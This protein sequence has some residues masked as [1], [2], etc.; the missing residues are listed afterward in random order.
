MR[1]P[2]TLLLLWILFFFLNA[3]AQVSI[4]LENCYT[5]A[6]ENYPMIKQRD[7][8]AKS[9]EYS[10]ENASKGYY[11]QLSFYGQATYQSQVTQIPIKL[12]NINIPTIS[13][14]QYKFYGEIN[15]TIYDGGQIRA[16]KESIKANE[17]IEVQK[18]ET[19]IY[20]LKERINQLYFGIL[21]VNEQLKQVDILKKDMASGIAKINA[22]I[23]NG[24][25]LKSSADALLVEQLKA[26]QKTIELKA[27]RNAYLEMLGLYTNQKLTENSIIEK[28]V[29]PA[30][31]NTIQRPELLLYY[32]QSRLLDVQNKLINVKNRPK[33]G[34]FFQGGFGRPALNMLNN[35][36][37]GYCIGGVRLSWSLNGFY[38]AKNDRVIIGINY[39]LIETQKETFLFN[40]NL[41]LKQQSTEI[42]KN[43]E[44]IRTDESIISLRTKIKIRH[45]HNSKMV[46]LI[47]QIMCAK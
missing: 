13:K 22:A 5:L 12:P 27:S 2:L 30:L 8:I 15:Q 10:I 42:N 32:N 33:V 47:L 16:Q 36:F 7:L 43:E 25:A 11:P 38:T 29:T 34:L 20:K 37:T 44:L 21:L 9:A 18:L 39:N 40:T 28:P 19:E 31:A 4:T 6:R 17:I 24:V 46:P 45:W 41:A 26:D 14:D 3:Q 1:L 35:E 23:A